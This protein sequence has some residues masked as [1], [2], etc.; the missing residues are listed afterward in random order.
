MITVMQPTFKTKLIEKKTNYGRFVLE[1]LQ[2]G[3]GY[4]VAN[5]LRRC[6]LSTLRGA[7]ITQIQIDG[8]RHQF[9][10]LPGVKEDIVELILNLKQVR[11]KTKEEKEIKAS[12]QVTGP[13]EIKAGDIKTPAGTEII[14]KEL[15]LAT[16]ADKKSKL[17]CKLW[18]NLGCGYSPAEDRKSAIVGVIPI[19]A[20]FSPIV[21]VNYR[22]EATRVGRWTD[23]DRVILEIWT[24]GTVKPKDALEEGARIL[25]AF[26]RQ[27][28]EPVFEK[29]KKKEETREDSEVLKLTVE[30]LDLPTRIANALHRG[31]YETVKDL[32]KAKHQDI[33]KVKNLGKKSIDTIMEKLAEKGVE[34]RN[35]T[36]KAG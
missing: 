1:P 30:E 24:D 3:Y 15:K 13:G 8:V 6:L 11:I 4:T 5:A 10:T 7:A 16:L 19:D 9:S 34:L 17:K 28:Y 21:K 32:L 29:E 31:G 14:N 36:Q 23:F 22:L 33:A 27:I 35:E 18:I 26:F 2:Q 20:T 25:T 12:L